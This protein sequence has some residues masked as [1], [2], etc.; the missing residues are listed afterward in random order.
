MVCAAAMPALA[1][2]PAFDNTGNS[3]LNGTY[4]FREV[5]YSVA[6]TGGDLSGEYAA[7]GTISFNG[8]GGYSIGNVTFNQCSSSGCNQQTLPATSGA[9]TFSASGYGY[10][11]DPLSSSIIDYGLI[12]NNTLIASATES[13]YNTLFIASLITSPVPTAASFQGNYQMVGFIPGSGSA[14]SAAGASFTL[15][16]DG[17]GNLGSFNISGYFAGGGSTVYNQSVSSLKYT[18]SSGAAVV[19]FPNNNNANFYPG[20]VYL[21]MSPDRNFV[22]GGSPN[23]FDMIV[24]TKNSGGTPNFSGIYYEAGLDWDA[25]QLSTNGASLDTYYGSYNAVNGNIIGHE[26]LLYAQ[27]GSADGFNYNSTYPSTISGN[28]YTVTSAPYGTQY[29]FGNNGA[30]RIGFGIGP[31][32]ALSVGLQAPAMT[33]SGV[34]LNPQGVVNAASYTPFTAGVSPGEIVVLYGTNL[35]PSFQAASTLPLPTTLNG[36]QVTVNGVPAPFYYVSPTQISVVIPYSAYYTVSSGFPIA[37][38][39]V[40]NSSGTSNAV[41]EFFNLSTPGVFTQ[42]ASGLGAPSVYHA[43]ANGFVAVTNSNPAQPG[44]TVVAYLS[45]LGATV[46]SVTEGSAAPASPLANTVNG[47]DVLVGGTEVCGAESNATPCP[48]VGLAPYLANVYQ[49]NIPIPSTQASGTTSLEFFGPDSDNYQV[50][51][52][53]GSG[54]VSSLDRTEAAPE[55]TPLPIHRRT[56]KPSGKARPPLCLNTDKNCSAVSQ[57]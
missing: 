11:T 45:G 43:T 52:P 37:R 41:T 19:N 47:F 28:T 51:I 8:A 57:M 23:G 5:V 29:F 34:Y 21:Y 32:L 3:L 13:G 53:V 9:F 35:A 30:I 50:A 36:V 39:V 31:S 38:I 27:S 56:V 33:G 2:L 17:N 25:T 7:F 46:P 54:N 48:Y 16:P 10:F 20:P 42:N 1:N 40:T 14:S 15:N 24:G 55:Q 18:F 44:E 4:Y 26:R 12:S 6:D 22:F 49:F